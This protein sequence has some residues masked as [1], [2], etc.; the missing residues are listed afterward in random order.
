MLFMRFHILCGIAGHGCLGS[1]VESHA[2][3]RDQQAGVQI[4]F[5]YAVDSPLV[6]QDVL[7]GRDTHEGIRRERLGVNPWSHFPFL[8]AIVVLGCCQAKRSER[9]RAGERVI[10]PFA[11]EKAAK[12]GMVR[13]PDY[14]H[15]IIILLNNHG[16]RSPTCQSA[17]RTII[18]Q[19]AEGFQYNCRPKLWPKSGRTKYHHIWPVREW[20]NWQ[21]Q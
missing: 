9:L 17:G 1:V 5:H 13:L 21:T 12:D 4:R 11:R 20:R 6:K 19:S 8:P 7:I 14:H 15:W 18:L 3:T 16:A 2:V 10:P